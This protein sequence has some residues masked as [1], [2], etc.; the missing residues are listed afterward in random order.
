MGSRR[1]AVFQNLTHTAVIV[2]HPPDLVGRHHRRFHEPVV[3]G[4]K[5]QGF[6]V[7]KGLH[8]IGFGVGGHRGHQ[9]FRADPPE[10]RTVKSRF[11]GK[12]QARHHAG[13]R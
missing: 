2:I 6:K 3:N 5:R 1:D 8:F 7:K 13:F 9:V 11:V 12:H 10:S 4:A